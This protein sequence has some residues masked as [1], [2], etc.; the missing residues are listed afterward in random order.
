[1]IIEACFLERG[2]EAVVSVW[3]NCFHFG[4]FT[5]GIKI[6]CSV[7]ARKLSRGVCHRCGTLGLTK[8]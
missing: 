5:L 8:E 3:R 4:G 7:N 6:L 1:M 2:R